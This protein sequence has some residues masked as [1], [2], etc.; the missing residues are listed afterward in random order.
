MSIS[1]RNKGNKNATGMGF[2]LQDVTKSMDFGFLNMRLEDREYFLDTII[3]NK[4]TSCE[5]QY[6]ILSISISFL[7]FLSKLARNKR[8]KNAT[9]KGYHLQDVAKFMDFRV[10]ES[11]L[12]S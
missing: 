7:Y 9:G 2:Q 1:A 6:Y 4:L 10:F 3:R 5:L 12:G 11:A 8:N